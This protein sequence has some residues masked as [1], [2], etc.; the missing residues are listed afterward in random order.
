MTARDRYLRAVAAMEAATDDHDRVVAAQEA[1]MA[2]QAYQDSDEPRTWRIG[3]GG[4]PWE[5]CICRRPVLCSGES[6]ECLETGETIEG[7]AKPQPRSIPSTPLE[8]FAN[9][10][11]A[12]LE[13]WHAG[14][15]LAQ[16]V[17]E[18]LWAAAECRKI[19]AGTR[20]DVE[21]FMAR[22]LR[23]HKAANNEKD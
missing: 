7:T 6:A 10:A 3:R 15:L 20:P 18:T 19:V 13:D 1:D 5:R 9:V 17:C 21:G 4:F 12:F 22:A 14:R 23:L 8:S 11:G 16:E 2:R